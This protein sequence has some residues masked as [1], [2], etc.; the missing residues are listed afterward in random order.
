MLKLLQ[1]N[2]NKNVK[3]YLTES[4]TI[5]H[6]TLNVTGIRK[7]KKYL[8]EEVYNLVDIMLELL[9]QEFLSNHCLWNKINPLTFIVVG[10]FGLSNKKRR[11]EQEE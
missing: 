7:S 5:R 9:T 11:N 6:P 3:Y 2:C 8:K 1:E 10:V 4:A